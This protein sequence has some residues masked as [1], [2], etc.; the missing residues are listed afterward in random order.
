[1]SGE[2][3]SPYPMSFPIGEGKEAWDLKIISNFIFR[4]IEYAG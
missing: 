3:K 1:M 4:S 2:K